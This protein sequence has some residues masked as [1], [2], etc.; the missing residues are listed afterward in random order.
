MVPGTTR[1]MNSPEFCRV[2]ATVWPEVNFELWLPSQ[3]NRKFVGV[4]NGGQ[5]GTISYGAMIA[6]LVQGYAIA[7]TDT[8][9]KASEAAWA[10]NHFQRIIDYGYRGTHVMTQAAKAITALGDGIYGTNL[11]VSGGEDTTWRLWP[12]LW[13]NGGDVLTADRT[14]SAFASDAGVAAL[15]TLRLA[16]PVH[17]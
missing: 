10:L 13:Q 5:A 3:W 6:P 1:T 16:A 12:L 14:K 4:G 17:H 9:H 8:G 15:E 2:I 7:S 11:S